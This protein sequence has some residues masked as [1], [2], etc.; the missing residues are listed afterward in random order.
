[1]FVFGKGA[2]RTSAGCSEME[3]RVEIA[4]KYKKEDFSF[5]GGYGMTG[6]RRCHVFREGHGC[7]IGKIS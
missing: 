4:I 5:A 6:L 1:M 7:G 2:N 3:P